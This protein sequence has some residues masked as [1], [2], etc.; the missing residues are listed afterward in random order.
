MLTMK[1]DLYPG[2]A[3]FAISMHACGPVPIV[4]GL[5]LPALWA[6]RAPL[7]CEQVQN[8]PQK[9]ALTLALKWYP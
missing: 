8:H 5:R 4:M 6:T 9:F 7:Q 2:V 1:K 3:W